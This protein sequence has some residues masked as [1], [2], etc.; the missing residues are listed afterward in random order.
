MFKTLLKIFFIFFL[1][2]LNNCSAPGTAFLG[3][4][5]T[6]IKTGSV[7]QTSMSYGSGR[8]MDVIKNKKNEVS[9]DSLLINEEI[10]SEK[11]PTI[12]VSKLLPITTYTIEISEITE[13]EPLP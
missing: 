13:P 5:F 8:I 4:A 10:N 11:K 9:Q 1:I 2:L 3:P 12:K 6:G 7:Y